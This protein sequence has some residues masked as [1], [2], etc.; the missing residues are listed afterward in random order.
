MGKAREK[1]GK[2][3][4]AASGQ[5][6]KVKERNERARL[7]KDR[8]KNSLYSSSADDRE[9][10]SQVE[11]IGCKIKF[12]EGDGNCLFRSLA[13]QL[14][15]RPQDHSSVRSKVMDHL[16]KNREVF[17]PY[18]E[19]DES[20]D[21]YLARMR[22]D[23]EW[24]GNQELVAASQLYRANVVV[25]QF[26]APR[27][28]IPCEK[29]VLTIHLSYHGEH[30]YNSVRAIGDE[31]NGRAL[32]ITL[33]TPTSSRGS[34]RVEGSPWPEEEAAVA[35]SC[36]WATPPNITA[37]LESTG[38]RGEDAIEL[39]IAARNEPGLDGNC[40]DDETERDDEKAGKMK[41]V[42]GGDA[43]PG[44]EKAPHENGGS[45][46]SARG[47]AGSKGRA[48]GN[49][50]PKKSEKPAKKVT[51]AADC[52]CGSGLKYKKCCRKRDAA[53]ARGQIAPPEPETKSGD[54]PL[55]DDLGS[56]VI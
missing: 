16:E 46:E 19:D 13:D 2:R 26:K 54:S 40:A 38:G 48:H 56:L 51:R 37:A 8:Q 7:R 31:G 14:D 35:R 29:A 15:G 17:E 21:D 33:Q 24:G 1:A 11:Q 23:A 28:F 22:R 47:G 41:P 3:G 9:F 30:H 55:V 52:P 49:G 10:E 34:S 39:L 18:V 32:P 53:V 45:A 12:I 5:S 44:G 25:H 42:E 36:P 50:K 4:A 20:F 6:D 43:D 27:F